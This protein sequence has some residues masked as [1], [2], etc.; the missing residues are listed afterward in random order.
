[1]ESMSRPLRFS[2]GA[3]GCP[4]Q[5]PLLADPVRCKALPRL[6]LKAQTSDEIAGSDFKQPQAGP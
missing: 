2:R 1:M 6:P 5:T 3:K 4:L